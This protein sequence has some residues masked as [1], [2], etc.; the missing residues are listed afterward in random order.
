MVKSPPANAGDTREAGSIP[1][2]RRSPAV[3]KGNPLQYSCLK[4]SMD[5]EAQRASEHTRESMRAR[6]N[7]VVRG[8]AY[9]SPSVS[10]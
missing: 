1:E 7:G 3:G 8:L 10:Y 9:L 2:S 4:N 6:G 5:K